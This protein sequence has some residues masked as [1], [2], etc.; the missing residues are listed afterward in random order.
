VE[1]KIQIKVIDIKIKTFLKKMTSIGLISNMIEADSVVIIIADEFKIVK[2]MRQGRCSEIK[3]HD[4]NKKVAR[5]GFE[6]N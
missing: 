2:E 5:D 1:I 6:A 3:R 4:A